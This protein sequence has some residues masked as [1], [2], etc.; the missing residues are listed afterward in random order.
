MI[1]DD[2][3]AAKKP[4]RRTVPVSLDPDMTERLD[5]A[6][7]AVR[8]AEIA[9]DTAAEDRRDV[10]QDN[11]DAARV[12]LDQLEAEVKAQ[13]VLFVFE[14]LGRKGYEE[15]MAN[16]PPTREQRDRL[17]A[18]GDFAPW[19]VDEFPP[20][21]ISACLVEPRLSVDE[22]RQIWDSPRWNQSECVDLFNTALLVCSQ[23]KG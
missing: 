5:A 14:G 6:R 7:R 9:L 13:T 23:R 22:V 12:D 11:L 2:L 8:V 10:A 15:L 20:I 16:H 19:N 3:L 18:T 1:L 4:Q 21:L 17:K